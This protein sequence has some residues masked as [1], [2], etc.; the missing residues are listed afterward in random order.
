MRLTVQF[1]GLLRQLSGVNECQHEV[2]GS[3]DLHD[4]GRAQG[5][6]YLRMVKEEVTVQDHELS[7]SSAFLVVFL[8]RRLIVIDQ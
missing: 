5:H 6:R 1:F 2:D 8:N 7:T 3:V 4:S